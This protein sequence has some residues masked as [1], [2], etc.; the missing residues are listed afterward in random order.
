MTKLYAF[1]DDW[2]DYIRRCP[3][4][5]HW[6]AAYNNNMNGIIRTQAGCP[7]AKGDVLVIQPRWL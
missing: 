3:K 5:K 1:I 6:G 4:Y 7:A 2:L